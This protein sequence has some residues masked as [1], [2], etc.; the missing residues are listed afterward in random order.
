MGEVSPHTMT[1]YQY[2]ISSWEVIL[3]F[4]LTMYPWVRQIN[5]IIGSSFGDIILE[6]QKEPIKK[7]TTQER[8]FQFSLLFLCSLAAALSKEN[9]GGMKKRNTQKD[10]DS[11]VE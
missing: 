9:G 10:R 7:E 4:I 11:S 1:Q 8:M 5:I 2:Q 3:L 6:Y